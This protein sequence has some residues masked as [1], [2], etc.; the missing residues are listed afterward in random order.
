[1]VGKFVTIFHDAYSHTPSIAH[2]HTRKWENFRKLIA[3]THFGYW[4]NDSNHHHHRGNDDD[5]D[6]RNNWLSMPQPG[7]ANEK[8]KTLRTI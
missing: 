4:N 6:E 8:K 2:T 5:V 3:K 7:E 1:M